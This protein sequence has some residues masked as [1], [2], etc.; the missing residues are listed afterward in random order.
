MDVTCLAPSFG[1]CLVVLVGIAIALLGGESRRAGRIGG[2]GPR[3]LLRMDPR[4]ASEAHAA[5][6]DAALRELGERL[7]HAIHLVERVV[8]AEPHRTAPPD[9]KSPSLVMISRA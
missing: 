9:S 6:R 4:V 1:L 3:G 8:V 2:R 5:T 7:E